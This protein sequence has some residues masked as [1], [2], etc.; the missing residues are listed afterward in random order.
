MD[1][2]EGNNGI[3]VI[4]A[5]NRADIL[6]T[7]LLRPGRFDRRVNVDLPNFQGRIAILKVGSLLH[8][9]TN[10]SLAAHIPSKHKLRTRTAARAVL[11]AERSPCLQSNFK[12]VVYYVLCMYAHQLLI[13]LWLAHVRVLR[14]PQVHA[15]G[16]PLS[17]DIDL[18]SIARRT[19]G[20]S[21][22]QLQNLM[23]EAAI[24][25]A[26][27]EKTIIEWED[28]DSALDRCAQQ[29]ARPRDAVLV[30]APS[31]QRLRTRPS[32]LLLQRQS[33]TDGSTGV[34]SVSIS[35]RL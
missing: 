3:I 29:A 9:C 23:N 27:T 32:L 20:Y 22:A 2:F 11:H 35:T 15:R 13:H 26:R 28:I 25:A 24:F 8:V 7:A 19:P 16:K 14:C 30:V 5:T 4:A 33:S 17:P 6:D 1:G 21:G 18:E 10:W 34:F 12:H 31:R